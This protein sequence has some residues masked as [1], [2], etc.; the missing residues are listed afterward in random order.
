M[1]RGDIRHPGPPMAPAETGRGDAGLNAMIHVGLWGGAAAACLLAVA[2]ATRTETGQGRLA[3]AFGAGTAQVASGPQAP[4]DSDVDAR[5]TLETIRNLTEDRDRLLARM[6][7]L[8]RNYEDVTGSIGRLANSAKP[9]A[10]PPAEPSPPA[11]MAPP[12]SDTAP[13]AS[14]PATEPAP[15]PVQAPAPAAAVKPAPP[16][17]ATAAA[18]AT[19][20]PPEPVSARSEFGVDIGGGPTLAS[21]RVAWDRIKRNHASLLDGL[22]P[23]IAIRD[24][25]GG[26]VELRL[27]VGPIAN[28]A[29]AARLCASLASAGLSCQ[30]TMF[31]GQRLALR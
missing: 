8:E 3:A 2:L 1:I 15:A 29:T 18:P 17:V 13:V 4:R 9:P 5:R 7:A 22:R 16:P 23:V 31:E 28:A 26:Q 21:L 14:I 10:M 27:I 11:Q 24:N 20:E 19:P 6:T 25:R 30:P 12:P